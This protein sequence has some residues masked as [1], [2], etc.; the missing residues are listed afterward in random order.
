MAKLRGWDFRRRGGRL[1]KGLIIQDW[2]GITY[3]RTK[4]WPRY[5]NSQRQKHVRSVFADA[6]HRWQTTYPFVRQLWRYAAKGKGMSGY[7]LFIK[8]WVENN[9]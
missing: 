1:G 9:T 4:P 6:V 3:V 2:K 8:I 5:S 7:E